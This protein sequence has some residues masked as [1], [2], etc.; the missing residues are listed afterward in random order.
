MEIRPC[1]PQEGKKSAPAWRP[2]RFFYLKLSFY[3]TVEPRR[4]ELLTPCL[5]SRCSAN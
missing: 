5:Q 2:K 3:E 1:F 4:I